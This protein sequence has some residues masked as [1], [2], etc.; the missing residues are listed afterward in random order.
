MLA[1][2]A[3]ET[4]LEPVHQPQIGSPAKLR[5]HE[6]AHKTWAE[7]AP[8]ED[9]K[10][11]YSAQFFLQ[12][13]RCHL[14]D[15]C[16]RLVLLHAPVLFL[17]C[18]ASTQSP[19]KPD[20]WFCH[21]HQKRIMPTVDYHGRSPCLENTAQLQIRTF[22]LVQ[23]QMVDRVHGYHSIKRIRLEREIGNVGDDKQPLISEASARF[24]QRHDGNI[25]TQA[26]TIIFRECQ[27]LGPLH[28]TGTGVEQNLSCGSK[29]PLHA[30]MTLVNVLARNRT[31]IFIAGILV[32]P[33]PGQRP[34]DLVIKIADL[35]FCVLS[36]ACPSTVFLSFFRFSSNRKDQG[37][38]ISPRKRF[39]NQKSERVSELHQAFMAQHF[40]HRPY[41]QVIPEI[42]QA[43][44]EWARIVKEKT[45][46]I[47]PG[48]GN[49]LF[50]QAMSREVRQDSF[51]RGKVF[52]P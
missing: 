4:L 11:E 20:E 8:W 42:H 43:P 6:P 35:L 44:R 40:F 9:F 14:F 1:E 31:Q 23:W 37:R 47:I 45:I 24:L 5:T 7:A 29:V 21:S 50:R 46:G 3:W 19:R 36:H 25:C 16:T 32:K 33:I 52:V 30:H 15:E 12:P 2:K 22:V 39:T 34:A 48:F 49:L 18:S 27:I 51:E 17:F 10:L 41:F 13:V 28:G 38:S 26:V